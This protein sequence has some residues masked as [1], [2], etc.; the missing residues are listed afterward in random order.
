MYKWR[1]GE[2]D[3]DQEGVCA[4]ASLSVGCCG[5]GNESVCEGGES[6]LLGSC[7]VCAE[8]GVSEAAKNNK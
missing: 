2:W 7:M 6:L 4:C 3:L 8:C 1:D 5:M